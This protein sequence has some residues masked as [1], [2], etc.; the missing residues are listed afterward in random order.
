[1][2]NKD[3]ICTIL[4]PRFPKS[5]IV[6]K[7]VKAKYY[8]KEDRAPTKYQSNLHYREG[9]LIDPDTGDRVLMN[10]GAVGKPKKESLSGN[11]S[12]YGNKWKRGKAI[13]FLKGFY[14]LFLYDVPTIT[15]FPVRIFW[16]LYTT[17]DKPD[18][19]LSN[20]WFYY[21]YFEDCL[22]DI[23]KKEG[24]PDKEP[25]LPDDSVRYITQSGS[26][27]LHP[28]KNDNERGFIFKIYA[29]NR[30]IIQNHRL[31]KD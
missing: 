31:W 3:Y 2:D 11:I 19:D 28:V 9:Y 14:M 22:R 24:E 4:I 26:P 30:T 21:K 5:M 13:E 27:L 17:V 8:T 7:N 16:D 15:T 1:M 29:D 18:F 6:S 10:P 25:I 23:R 12:G 20:Y